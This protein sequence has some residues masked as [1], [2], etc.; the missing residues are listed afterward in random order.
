MSGLP[1][2]NFPAF[3]QAAASLRALGYTVVSPHECEEV[4][5]DAPKPWEYYVRKD[6]I[7][8]LQ[9]CD[10]IVMLDGWGD[11]NGACLE[12]HVATHLGFAAY[13]GVDSVPR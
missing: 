3:E 13:Y 6:L 2:H 12:Y 7:A 10:T 9:T 11:S 4:H 5:H 8:M 1:L